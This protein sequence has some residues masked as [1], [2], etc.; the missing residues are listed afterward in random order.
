MIPVRALRTDTIR[1]W[2]E[3]KRGCALHELQRTNR[4]LTLSGAH[5]TGKVAKLIDLYARLNSEVSLTRYA[6]PI[7]T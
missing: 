6:H 7:E 1:R 2:R 5:R 3:L 4:L